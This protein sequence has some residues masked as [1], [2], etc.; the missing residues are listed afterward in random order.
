MSGDR[1]QRLHQTALSSTLL[2]QHQLHIIRWWARVGRLAASVIIRHRHGRG[3]VQHHMH[4][5][6]CVADDEEVELAK[7]MPTLSVLRNFA[8][9][10][11]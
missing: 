8:Y 9:D 6:G 7:R 2:Y 3:N 1:R 10:M 5:P 11:S 4:N